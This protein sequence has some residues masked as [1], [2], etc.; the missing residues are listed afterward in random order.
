MVNS[1]ILN[2][3]NKSKERAKKDKKYAKRFFDKWILF[4]LIILTSIIGSIAGYFIVLKETGSS[5][6]AQTS[7]IF[8]GGIIGFVIMLIISLI[9]YYIYSKK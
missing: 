9:Y 4:L 1:A 2:K 5:F 7:G 3:L 6:F 8:Y